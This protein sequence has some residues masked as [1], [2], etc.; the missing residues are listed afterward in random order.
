MKKLIPNKATLDKIKLPVLL[1]VFLAVGLSLGY[2]FTPKKDVAYEQ[3]IEAQLLHERNM[4]TELFK[5]VANAEAR[6]KKWM[7]IEMLYVDS[8]KVSRKETSSW[9][10]VYANINKTAAPKYSEP[11]LDTLISAIIR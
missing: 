4:V 10:K 9:K 11:E 7:E 3:S 6:E 2:I 1:I 5:K 8:L